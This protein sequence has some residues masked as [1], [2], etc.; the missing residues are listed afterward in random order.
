MTVGQR[1]KQARK[2]AGITRTELAERSGVPYPTLAGLENGDQKT[3]TALPA[4]AQVLGVTALWLST[5]RIGREAQT[6]QPPGPPQKNSDHHAGLTSHF[7]R[8]TPA[9]LAHAEKWVRF[10]EGAGDQYTPEGRA[11][12]LFALCALAID[13]GGAISPDHSQQLID[14]ARERQQKRGGKRG[15]RS[16]EA[17]GE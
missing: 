4:L 9:I 11:E 17:G 12:R 8:L 3:S 6:V 7:G 16:T 2:A 1:I 10:E 13:D 14:A 5:G 15:G